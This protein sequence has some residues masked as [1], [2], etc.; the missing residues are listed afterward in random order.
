MEIV[1]VEIPWTTFAGKPAIFALIFGFLAMYLFKR[2]T[3]GI[4]AAIFGAL[5]GLAI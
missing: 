5:V 3:F 2:P 4:V 1:P